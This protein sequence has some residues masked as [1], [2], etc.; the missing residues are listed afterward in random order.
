MK[1]QEGSRRL[2]KVEEGLRRHK[3]VQE[4]SRMLKKAWHS[5]A[6]PPLSKLKTKRNW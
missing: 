3:K 1:V 5:M 4:G 6:Y 2:K